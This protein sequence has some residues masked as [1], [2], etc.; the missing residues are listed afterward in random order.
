MKGDYMDER[1]TYNN[2]L[3]RRKILKLVGGAFHFYDPM[4]N[5]V[6]YAK[7]KAFKLKEDITIYSGEDMQEAMI[8][9]KARNIIDFSAT[10]DVVD[11]Q[12]NEKVGGLRRKGLKSILKDEWLVLDEF[13]N[14]IGV[15]KEDNMA[16]ALVRRFLT[17][18]VPQTYN[19]VVNNS[20]VCTYKQN[21]NPF[22]VKVNVDFSADS[23]K[24]FDRR[25]GL[26]AGLLLCAIEGKQN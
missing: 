8:S 14:E 15:I 19:C 24:T 22:V 9:I 2:Y 17:N 7:M 16:L 12:T 26:A 21:F 25:L 13:D 1:Y 20:D 10:Y 11:A 18:L 6:L 5:V 4:G 23:G 3:V